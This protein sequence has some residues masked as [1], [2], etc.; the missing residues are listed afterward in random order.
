MLKKKPR[1]PAHIVLNNRTLT[2]FSGSNYDTVFFS[3]GLG[4]IMINERYQDDPIQC[5]VVK[6]VKARTQITLCSFAESTKGPEQI[7]S[8]WVNA[9]TFFRSKCFEGM[10]IAPDPDDIDPTLAMKRK[11][12]EEETMEAKAAGGAAVDSRAAAAM[13]KSMQSLQALALDAIGKEVKYEQMMENEERIRQ[14]DEQKEL[15]KKLESMKLKQE[16]LNREVKKKSAKSEADIREKQVDFDFDGL[17]DEIKNLIMRKRSEQSKRIEIMK[18]MGDRRKRDIYN[19]INELQM[20]MAKDMLKAEKNV[21]SSLCDPAVNNK[22]SMNE[23][24]NSNINDD[25]SMNKDCKDPDNFCYICCELEVGI[26]YV[27]KRDACMGKCNKGKKQDKGNWVWVPESNKVK[28][29]R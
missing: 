3:V 1:L 28:R 12:L 5:F 26:F 2:I 24:C 6:N 21:N 8:E 23:Y 9:I 13:A 29:R 19:Q 11:D 15:A 10:K 4:D 17:K 27:A 7:K 25:P 14:E 20:K 22:E 16:C 18:K